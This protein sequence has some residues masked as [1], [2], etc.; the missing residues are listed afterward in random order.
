[1]K[2]NRARKVAFQGEA[3]AFSHAAAL[4]L[5]GEDSA[6]VP[7]ESFREVF[8]ALESGA[9]THAVIPIENTLHGSVLENYDHLVKY[10]FPIHGETSLRIAHQLIA[11]PGTKMRNVKRVFS[12]PVALNQCRRFFENNAQLSAEPFYDTAGSA[13]MLMSE[14]PEGAAAIA[15][16]EAAEL[17][18]G[19]ILKRNIEDDRKNFTR[20]F[21]LTK[22][23]PAGF[24]ADAKW[25][26]SVAF[27]TS[28]TPGSLFR[29][30]AC[31]ALRDI[32]LIKIESRPIIGSPW[33]YLF[34]VDFLGSAEDDRVKSA[35]A[36]LREMTK[37]YKLLGNYLP[38]P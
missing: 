33:E 4:K 9:A 26:I 22:Q 35:L 19:V 28:N 18:G 23:R 6:I 21:L 32:N 5:A 36:N 10:D 7:C 17:Y 20:F 30:M 31:L 29:A 12:H 27:G 13:K 24:T 38:T 3:G 1:V 16:K 11:A 8:T 25:K 34:Y 2:Q 37:F 15:S 14:R